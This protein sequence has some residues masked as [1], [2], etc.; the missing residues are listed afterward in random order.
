MRLTCRHFFRDQFTESAGGFT[1]IEVIVALAIISVLLLTA[2]VQTPE[3]IDSFQRK[4]ARQT[5]DADIRRARAEA[6]K[7]GTRCVVQFLAG[8]AQYRIGFDRLP[9]SNTAVPETV[10]VLRNLPDDITASSG[11]PIIFDSRGYLITPEGQPA[12]TAVVLRQRG[13]PFVTGSIFATGLVHYD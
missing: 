10:L 1:L 9:Y 7:E 8:G 13:E 2:A 11:T 3:L 12:Q 6:T 5:F 4:N